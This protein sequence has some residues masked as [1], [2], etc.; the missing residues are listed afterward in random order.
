M[1]EFDSNYSI[2]K[3]ATLCHITLKTFQRNFTKHLACSPVEY[4]RIARF[5][6]SLQIKLISNEIETLTSVSNDS[7]YYDQSYFIR[8]FKKLTQLNPKSFF[9]SITALEEKK[10]V[11]KVK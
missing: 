8:E 5:R 4:K 9:N 10:V 3:I 11:W 2:D 1:E 6:H 7:N